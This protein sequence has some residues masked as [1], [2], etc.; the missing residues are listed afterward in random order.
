L[1][2]DSYSTIAVWLTRFNI[3]VV[4]LALIDRASLGFAGRA[5]L[6]MEN[7][8]LMYLGKISYGLYL[9]HIFI[10]DIYR[11]LGLPVFASGALTF[12]TNLCL[13]VL[14]ASASWQFFERPVN[15]LKKRFSYPVRAAI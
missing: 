10:P 9:F 13:L 12:A 5:R 14:L 11:W 2:K 1:L 8:V 4:A 3:S 6:L 7:P 15:S